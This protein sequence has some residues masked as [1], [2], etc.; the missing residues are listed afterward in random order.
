[1]KK[2]MYPIMGM[3]FAVLWIVLAFLGGGPVDIVLIVVGLID[4]VFG[5]FLIFLPV[6]TYLGLYYILVGACSIA[7]ARHGA[8]GDAGITFTLVVT[9]LIFFVTGGLTVFSGTGNYI[10]NIQSYV[11]NCENDMNIE[12]WDWKYYGLDTRCENW[13][14]FIVFCV[15]LLFLVQPLGIIAAFFKKSGGGGGGGGGHHSGSGEK[16]P[17]QH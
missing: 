10:N 9:V 5:I 7:V 4:A 14:L 13:A 3:I 15:F 1:M 2:I 6:T 8:G 11:G 17:A 12:N 16:V